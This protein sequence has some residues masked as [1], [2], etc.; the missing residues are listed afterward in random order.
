MQL[1]LIISNSPKTPKF[2]DLIAAKMLSLRYTYALPGS[3]YFLAVGR[4]QAISE[5]NW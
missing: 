2:A 4:P 1:S 5:E 3:V